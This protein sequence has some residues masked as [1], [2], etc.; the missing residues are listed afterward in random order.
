M[1]ANTRGRSL[2]RILRCGLI[3]SVW[4][5]KKTR[6]YVE[7]SKYLPLEITLYESG[8]SHH[9]LKD[10]F[11]LVIS[12]TSRVMATN[13]A[14]GEDPFQYFMKHLSCAPPSQH[15]NRLAPTMEKSATIHHFY[16]A[17]P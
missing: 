16:P 3:L 11:L 13:V 9:Y 14:V 2:P 17:S 6:V 5:S 4:V 12:H 7:R 1:C 10:V 15:L 8:E